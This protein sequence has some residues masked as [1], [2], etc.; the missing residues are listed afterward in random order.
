VGQF[1]LKEA[2]SFLEIVAVRKGRD[3][4]P[5]MPLEERK[6][7][8]ENCFRIPLVIEWLV[9]SAKDG[10]SLVES[11]RRLELAPRQAEEVLEFSFRRIH[12]EL[13]DK[14]RKVLTALGLF[15]D[16]QPIEALHAACSLPFDAVSDALEELLDASLVIPVFDRGL[17]DTTYTM[18]PITRR[19]S[20]SELERS[21]ELEQTLR[22]A[23]TV[24]YE[25]GDISDS[26]KRKVMV[27]IRRA[28]KDPE[29]LLVDAGRQMRNQGKV[30]DAEQFFAQA[31]QRNPTSWRANRELADLY[32]NE[33]KTT[34]ALERYSK[35]ASLAP[36]RGKD[37]ALI[38]REYGILLRDA[39]TPDA[40][41]KATEALEEALKETPND[42][43]CVYVLS[44]VL[45]RRG[46]YR[47]ATPFLE[48]L[49]RSKDTQ[50]R[51]KAYPLLKK[52][53]EQDRD[54]LKLSELRDSAAADGFQL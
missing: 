20:H 23:L 15:T 52:C 32:K 16:P 39:A 12:T 35:A 37:R 36:K 4:I 25:G 9:G 45:C 5:D 48:G 22:R 24:W 11:A 29:T 14:T 43:V 54:L 26:A 44:Q 50:S 2:L 13:H 7:V 6:L 41:S 31:L 38:Y 33:G 30:N 19:F 40:L 53:Y 42:S 34:F 28:E 47:K 49:A 17:N 1:E 46:M 10:A 21:P 27:A 8:I 3:F 51:Q 18:L